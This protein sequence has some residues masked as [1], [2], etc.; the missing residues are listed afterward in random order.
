MDLATQQ[1]EAARNQIR[2]AQAPVLGRLAT[3]P[4]IDMLNR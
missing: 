1:A 3:Q 2:R 4:F